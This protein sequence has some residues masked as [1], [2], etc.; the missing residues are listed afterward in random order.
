MKFI[1][2]LG[3]NNGDRELH[4]QNALNNLEKVCESVYPSTHYASPAI[5]GGKQHYLNSVAIVDF[6]G[7]T[8]ELESILKHFEVIEGRTPEARELGLVPLDIDVVIAGDKIL[9]PHDY[10]RYFFKRGYEELKSLLNS[11]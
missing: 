3:S 1:L 5:G 4:L 2:S 8:D 6:N 10:S 9:R 11:I 7:D